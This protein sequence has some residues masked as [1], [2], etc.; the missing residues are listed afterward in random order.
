MGFFGEDQQKALPNNKKRPL[1]NGN[2]CAIRITLSDIYRI[3]INTSDADSAV[4]RQI[5]DVIADKMELA[6]AVIWCQF[7]RFDS[8]DFI[9][10]QTQP[11]DIAHI[12]K[13]ARSDHTQIAFLDTQQL[14]KNERQ[15][16]MR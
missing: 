6:D 9:V 12:R 7:E 4:V 8:V 16:M 14:S 1:P 5:Q 2:L 13:N 10:G 3:F 11:P 15:S